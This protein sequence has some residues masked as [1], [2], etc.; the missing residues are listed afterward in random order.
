MINNL[1]IE[2]KS[3]SQIIFMFFLFLDILTNVEW[4]CKKTERSK[5]NE[6]EWQFGNIT[7]HLGKL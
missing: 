5:I 1:N 2:N 4:M 6:D 7:V 3:L